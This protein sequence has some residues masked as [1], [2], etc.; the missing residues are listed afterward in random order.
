MARLLL[1]RIHRLR[2]IRDCSKEYILKKDLISVVYFSIKGQLP[3]YMKH[4][5]YPMILPP[6]LQAKYDKQ[7]GHHAHGHGGH[8]EGHHGD[9][10]EM[11][12]E[13][14]RVQA[15]IEKLKKPTLT[16]RI[17]RYASNQPATPGFKLERAKPVDLIQTPNLPAKQHQHEDKK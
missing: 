4:H 9:H 17:R 12:A 10:H 2:R 5:P 1:S 13:D 6:E 15:L 11:T 7:T 3:W 16:E 14:K 8:G